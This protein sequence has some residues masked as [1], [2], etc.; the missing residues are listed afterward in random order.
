MSCTEREQ[1]ATRSPHR[2]DLSRR[3]VVLDWRQ[4]VRSALLTTCRPCGAGNGA[5]CCATRSPA[6]IGSSPALSPRRCG[7][8]GSAGPHR[9]GCLRVQ[10]GARHGGRA[11]QHLGLS[12]AWLDQ[13]RWR[14]ERVVA[15]R[16]P[17][18]RSRE[19]CRHRRLRRR[20]HQ[21]SRTVPPEHAAFSQ[22]AR[23]AVYPYGGR[24]AECQIRHADSNYCAATGAGRGVRPNLY[25]A[26][27]TS[28][29][30]HALFKKA[31]G[32]RGIY[33]IAGR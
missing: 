2:R 3:R 22:F 14:G 8:R 20:R 32:P 13:S 5:L 23:D 26:T 1:A 11:A 10:H 16:R 31:S 4:W 33:R 7:W 12:A 15:L 27:T 9:M 29:S 21:P 30:P 24:R 6:R 18:P 28:A 19:R 25:R 17:P